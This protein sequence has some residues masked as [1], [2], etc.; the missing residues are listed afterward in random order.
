MNYLQKQHDGDYKFFS[1]ETG[2]VLGV[3]VC[4]D[5][6]GQGMWGNGARKRGIR[7]RLTPCERGEHFT[8]YT[9]DFGVGGAKSGGSVMLRELK[10]KS[11]KITDLIAADV[12]TRIDEIVGRWNA[13]DYEEAFE[14]CRQLKSK[15]FVQEAPKA[16]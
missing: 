3:E 15:W 2:P 14:I 4:Y 13:G 12:D 6:G 8:T 16:A 7:L 11:Q 5:L 1:G 9:I 10:R